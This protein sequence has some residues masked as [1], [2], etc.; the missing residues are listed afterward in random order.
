MYTAL[1]E[2]KEERVKLDGENFKTKCGIC[3]HDAD[4][5]ATQKMFVD[6]DEIEIGIALCENCYDNL[7]FKIDEIYADSAYSSGKNY[8]IY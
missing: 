3:K 6:G 1:V 2:L 8:Q 5:K 4:L 7:R